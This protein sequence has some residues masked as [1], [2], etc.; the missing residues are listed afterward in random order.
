MTAIPV[1]PGPAVVHAGAGA[2]DR[3]PELLI[4]DE[5][6]RVLF[7]HGIRSLRAA[8]PFLPDMPEVELTEA[9]FRGECS[10]NE[11]ERLAVLASEAR[12]QGVL[13][14]GGGKALD[15]AKAVARRLDLPVYLVP[16]LASTCS[17]WSAV[18]VYYD[19][20]HRHLGHE[21]WDVP[22]RGLFVDAEVLFDSPVDLFV[23]GVADTL[24]KHVET[25]AAFRRRP[26]AD[27]LASFGAEAAERCGEL[28][29]TLGATAVA[30]MRRGVRSDAWTRLAEAAIITSGLVG[31]LGAAF[32]RA[33][34]AHPVGDGLSAIDATRDLLHGVKV[35]YGILVQLAF[36]ERWDE[37]DDLADV[38]AALGLPRR[39]ADLGVD[40]DAD[41]VLHAIAEAALGPESSFHLL[42]D[43]PDPARLVELLRTLE[44]HQSTLARVP[45]AGV[46]LP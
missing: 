10:P 3:L 19:D 9:Q 26:T 46:A 30:D 21:V 44:V 22:T 38:Y 25:R 6:Q 2:L 13:G 14:L 18:T 35:A 24:A 40:A 23:S 12:V 7:V 5:V 4:G 11:I 29:R 1:R 17:G 16:T 43:A 15:T 33:T 20:A 32:G 8:Q 34:A 37:I 45:L 27:A 39:L 42:E 28:V 31:G 36:E 41:P